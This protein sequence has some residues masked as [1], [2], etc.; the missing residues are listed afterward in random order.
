MMRIGQSEILMG[1][2]TITPRHR[3]LGW[4]ATGVMAFAVVFMLAT[5]F[6]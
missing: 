2:L 6:I 5:S 3:L 4:I 1:K